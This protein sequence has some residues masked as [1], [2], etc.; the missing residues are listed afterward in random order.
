MRETAR[1]FLKKLLRMHVV[2]EAEDE[3]YEADYTDDELV[4]FI[5]TRD[6]ETLKEAAE[7]VAEMKED[8]LDLLAHNDIFGASQEEISCILDR[9]LEPP[10]MGGKEGARTAR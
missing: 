1:E 3:H 6:R 7:R 10:V 2:Y 5:E 8:I 4:S 9:S